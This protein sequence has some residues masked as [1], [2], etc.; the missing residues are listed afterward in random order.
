MAKAPRI[1][2]ESLERSLKERFP[3]AQFVLDR[4]RTPSGVWFLEIVRAGHPA[5]VQWQKGKAFG[6]SAALEHAYGEPADEVYNDEE[7]AYGRIVS[8]LLSRTF[9]SPPP[10]VSLKELRKET[11]LSQVELAAL[12][13][14]QQGEVSKIERRKDVRLSTLFDYVRALQGEL[15][16]IV[17]WKD[18]SSRRV[19]FDGPVEAGSVPAASRRQGEN[20]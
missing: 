9:T 18:G 14:S 12:L 20:P 10:A 11:G 3:D 19:Q 7:A 4:P 15:Q 13:D 2:I 6:I 5:I 17:R 8:L 16:I 1:P